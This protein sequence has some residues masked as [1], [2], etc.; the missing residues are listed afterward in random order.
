MNKISMSGVPAN[1]GPRGS[2][3]FPA[4]AALL[5]AGLGLVACSQQNQPATPDATASAA[6]TAPAAASSASARMTDDLSSYRQMVKLNNDQLAVTMGHDILSRYPGSDAAKEVQQTL[7][8]IE[9]R[10][11]ANGEKNRLAGLWLYQTSP[12]EGGIQS[13]ATIY[14]SQP[15]GN[16]GVRLVLRRHSSWGQSVFLFGS[17]KG[18]VCKSV[19]TIAATYDGKPHPLK[20][21]L[22]PTGEPAI[23][24]KDDPAFIAALP[25]VKKIVL[26][27]TLKD[28][29]KK[30]ELIYEVGGFD[31]SKWATV[32]LGKKK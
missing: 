25:K 10:Y 32:N 13:T 7:P 24:I 1:L 27:V 9:Q 11:H 4:I 31:S 28:G 5:A 26:P 2:A 3:R 6:S 20:A 14:S 15:S 19:C 30:Q 22:P 29:N 16:D 12:M 18:F 17:G 23:F 21:F 8:A